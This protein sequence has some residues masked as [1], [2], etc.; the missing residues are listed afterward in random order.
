MREE[1]FLKRDV[2][3]KTRDNAIDVAKGIFIISMLVGHFAIN[4]M[5]RNIIYSCHM[6]AFVFF[7]GYFYKKGHG[8][9]KTVRHII[10]NFLFPYV[11]FVISVILINYKNLNV[12]YLREIFIKYSMGMSFSKRI[13]SEI[14]SI[15]P[16][17]F[18]LMLFFIRI[19]YLFVDYFIRSE[20]YKLLAVTCISIGGMMLGKNG[21]WLPWSI[22][23]SC[24]AMIFYEIGIYCKKYNLLS[25]VKNCH[26]IY[27]VLSPVWVYMIYAGSMEIAVRNYGQYGL[28]IIGAVAGILLIYKLSV[29]IS[30]E[31]PVVNEALSLTGESSMI[32]LVLHTLF[33][34]K[35]NNLVSYRFDRRYIFYLICTVSL[36]IVLSWIIKKSLDCIKLKRQEWHRGSF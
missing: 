13:F 11:V 3:I 20:E 9:K 25:R 19:I 30:N 17:Y 36:Q 24:Y 10:H 1:G 28:V 31:L 7:S 21:I 34:E 8:M 16:V 26:I 33:G 2:H 4:R 29:Y 23:I 27:F 15:G 12:K 14:P 5:L 22:D 6:V 35:I 32:L 18:I